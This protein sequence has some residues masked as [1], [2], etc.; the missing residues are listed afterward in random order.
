MAIRRCRFVAFEGAHGT[1]KST[2]VHA[3]V[4]KL[5]AANIH[6]AALAEVARLSPFV[7][8]VVIGGKDEFDVAAELHLFASQVAQE[9]LLSRHHDVVV[10]DKTLANVLAYAEMFLDQSDDDAGRVLRAMIEFTRAYATRYD[11]VFYLSDRYDLSQT[12]DPFRP[13]DRTFQESADVAVK[14]ACAKVGI[15]PVMMPNGLSLDE[16]ITWLISSATLSPLL[17]Q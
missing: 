10:C 13:R 16:K 7:E 17:R 5:K 6:A 11:A 8:D 3:L 14:Q 15:V 9:Q 1:G 12:R 4:A 2:L